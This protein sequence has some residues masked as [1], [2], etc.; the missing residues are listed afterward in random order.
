MYLASTCILVV[1]FNYQLK[2]TTRECIITAKRFVKC[3][4]LCI[5]SH[6]PKHALAESVTQSLIFSSECCYKF[7][8]STT[9]CKSPA[10]QP[11]R[12]C[13]ERGE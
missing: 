3:I 4:V 9:G 13:I 7:A 6:P 10:M 2:I 5:L 8:S 1:I 11:T 12:I